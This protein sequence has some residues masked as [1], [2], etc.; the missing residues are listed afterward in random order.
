MTQYGN[1]Y[2]DPTLSGT[3]MPGDGAGNSSGAGERAQATA[4]AAQDAARQTAGTAREQAGVVAD[5]AKAKGSEVA[6]TAKE[7]A[8]T[9]I[10]ETKQQASDVLGQVKEQATSQAEAQRDRATESLRSLSDELRTM[11]EQGG[12]SGMAT[13][14]AQQISQRMDDLAGFLEQ[15]E[16]GDLINEVR[17]FARRRPGAFLFGAVVAGVVAGRMFKGATAD[18]TSST[19]GRSSGA[20]GLPAVGADSYAPVD[21]TY[22]YD[23]PAPHG[24]PMVALPDTGYS[25]H[26][27]SAAGERSPATGPLADSTLTGTS[28]DREPY[29][30]ESYQ[31]TYSAGRSTP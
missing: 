22:G 2:G 6:Q 5:T 24:D 25:V 10:N 30:T 16:P 15:R 18:S 21:A 13:T 27:Q 29:G 28:Y 20:P 17:T 4:G 14:A 1:T 23:S 9:V 19:S 7:Q 3:S 12:Q 11:A 8:S 31:G 26:G